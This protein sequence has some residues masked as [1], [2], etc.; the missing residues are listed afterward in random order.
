M[1]AEQ[2][3]EAYIGSIWRR[4]YRGRVLEYTVLGWTYGHRETRSRWPML[5]I[6]MGSGNLSYSQP[7]WIVRNCQPV[8]DTAL[9]IA[10]HEKERA[11]NG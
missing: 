4:E 5:R 3:A 7:R 2:E 8:N 10:E 9:T 11:G 1:T 6:L